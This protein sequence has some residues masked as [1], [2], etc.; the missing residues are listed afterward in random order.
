M[1]TP[2][3]LAGDNGLSLRPVLQKNAARCA[4]TATPFAEAAAHLCHSG[5]TEPIVITAPADRDEVLRQLRALGLNDADVLVTPCPRGSAP[6]ILAAAMRLGRT[7][8]DLLLIC[9]ALRLPG[10]LARVTGGSAPACDL[11]GSGTPVTF[12]LPAGKRAFDFGCLRVAEDGATLT[13]YLAPPGRAEAA[14][15]AT[16]SDH[17]GH[18]QVYLVRVD[19][20]ID[21]FA[22][23]APRRLDHCAR[24]LDRS[25]P[26]NGATLLD[27]GSFAEIEMTSLEDILLAPLSKVHVVPL[28]ID[29]AGHG[30]NHPFPRPVPQAGAAGGA[31]ATAE[32]APD[33]LTWNRSGDATVVASHP[34]QA[35]RMR[36]LH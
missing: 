25:L 20:L 30:A 4:L 24:A 2:V 21:A 31:P 12:G 3:L 16:R 28:R 5:C 13:E 10:D 14:Q 1:I 35:P 32:R 34:A 22:A 29:R 17:L 27:A 9:T 23:R 6:A 26:V 11:A 19:C 8:Q 33:P 15:L 36:F 18:S 7:S